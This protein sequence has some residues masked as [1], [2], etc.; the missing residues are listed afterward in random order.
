[1]SIVVAALYKFVT[2]EDFHEL[3]Q[4]LLDVCLQAEIRGSLLLAREGINGTIAGTRVGIDQ[5]LA[6]LR[7]DPRF[8][9]LEHKESLDER[10]PFLRMKVKLKKEIVTLGVDGIDPNELVGTYVEPQDWNAII[11]D[12]SV[13]VLDTRNDYEVKVGTFRGAIN[14]NTETFRE[15]PQFTEQFDPAQYQKVAMFCT[16]GIRCEKASAFMLQQGFGE[17]YHLR[18]GI[19]KY[20]EEVPAESSLWDGEC[21]VFDHRVTVDH[22]LQKGHFELC[23][24][25][26]W[27]VSE[28]EMQTPE[29]EP[30]VSCPHCFTTVTE[31][32]KL[33][34]RERRKQIE[35][36]AARGEQHVGQPMPRSE[37]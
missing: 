1:M 32:Q 29:F 17:V 11:S 19:L 23:H 2:L 21:F 12:P 3:R 30:G 22:D 16:G 24:G 13:L 35:L 15:F 37:S 18:G 36:A 28:T 7:A 34:F 10:Q 25:C 31:E 4:P 6:F 33:R 14:P 8:A 9:D 20:L 27:P 5:V 26:G